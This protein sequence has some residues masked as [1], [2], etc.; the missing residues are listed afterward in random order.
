MKPFSKSESS[1]IPESDEVDVENQNQL[2]DSL[3]EIERFVN[4]DFSGA[5][6]SV[7]YIEEL[8]KLLSSLKASGVFIEYSD[9]FPYLGKFEI[10]KNEKRSYSQDEI[11]KIGILADKYSQ[12]SKLRYFL[13]KRLNLSQKLDLSEKQDSPRN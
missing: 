3:P 10:L 11:V 5:P 6:P 12:D 8:F 13:N 9:T 7:E 1:E 2:E 4:L